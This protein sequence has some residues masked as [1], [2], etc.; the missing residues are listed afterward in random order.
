MKTP[1]PKCPCG[2]L[3]DRFLHGIWVCLDCYPWN[4]TIKPDKN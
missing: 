2:K 4:W 1:K 3:A